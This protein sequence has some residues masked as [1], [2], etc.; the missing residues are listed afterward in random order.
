MHCHI[1]EHE[2]QGAMGWTDVL[3]GMG[4]PVFPGGF[5]YVD[6]IEPIFPGGNTPAAPDGLIANAASSSQIDLSWN[7]KSSNETTFNIE[8]STDGNNFSFLDFVGTDITAFSD[9]SL[10]A[11]TTM[12]YRVSASNANGTSAYSNIA[13]DTTLSG[14]TATSVQVGSVTVTSVSA[15]KGQKN[16][17]A[18]IV[19]RDDLGA[20]V[21]NATVSG[22]FS[23]DI[24]EPEVTGT[25]GQNGSV[26]FSTTATFK[27][28]ISLT[29]CVNSVSHPSLTGYSGSPVCGSL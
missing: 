23:G 22:E 27:G 14:G 16:G 10:G 11:G 24:D 12:Y 15:G 20:L 17:K 9:T 13:S 5:G 25:T 19:V 2:D 26:S 29:F 3:G 7:D 21:Q 4:P 6:Y 1:L 8:N 28:T 18:T